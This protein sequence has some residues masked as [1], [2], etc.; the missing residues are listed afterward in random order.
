ML[1][2]LLA[3]LLAQNAPF[4][5]GFAVP[6]AHSRARSSTS[7]HA[8]CRGLPRSRPSHLALHKN[9]SE[10]SLKEQALRLGESVSEALKE[11]VTNVHHRAV[12]K[13]HHYLGREEVS[14]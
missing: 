14:V 6:G 4:A 7:A 11:R 10:E 1:T 3:L 8:R 9:E 13:F 2:A 12:S 5:E